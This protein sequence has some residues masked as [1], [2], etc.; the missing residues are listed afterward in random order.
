MI[1][2]KCKEDIVQAIEI[3]QEHLNQPDDVV[4]NKSYWK[5]VFDMNMSR[6]RTLIYLEKVEKTL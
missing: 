5:E 1:M 6:L 3:A 2:K 4:D